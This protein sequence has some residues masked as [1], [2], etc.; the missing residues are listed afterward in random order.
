MRFNTFLLI[1]K[2]L[3]PNKKGNTDNLLP[4][5]NLVLLKERPLN[6]ILSQ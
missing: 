2:G 4:L 5:F 3:I 1:Y 6:K